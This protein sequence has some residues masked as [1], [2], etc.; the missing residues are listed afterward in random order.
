MEMKEYSIIKY[1]QKDETCNLNEPFDIGCLYEKN[2]FRF[3]VYFNLIST[4]LFVAMIIVVL[5]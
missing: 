5:A 2:I 1:K 4:V 3:T